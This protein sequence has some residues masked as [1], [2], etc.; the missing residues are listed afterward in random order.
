[1]AAEGTS[2]QSRDRGSGDVTEIQCTSLGTAASL[3]LEKRLVHLALKDLALKSR[4]RLEAIR[5]AGEIDCRAR[6][7]TCFPL[8]ES[9][10]KSSQ[11][12]SRK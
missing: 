9:G 2:R 12:R 4:E 3:E 8:S 11:R 7:I 5:A 10:A 1:M 6:V